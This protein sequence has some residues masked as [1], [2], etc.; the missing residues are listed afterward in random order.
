MFVCVCACLC[1]WIISSFLPLSWFLCS[2]SSK[3]VIKFSLKYRHWIYISS[4]A[5]SELITDSTDWGEFINWSAWNMEGA[6]LLNY[7]YL[8][9][10][11]TNRDLRRSSAF[12]C[13]VEIRFE[14]PLK[15]NERNDDDDDMWNINYVLD[16]IF[17]LS[18]N[19]K[20]RC[21]C[22]APVSQMW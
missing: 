6:A 11:S 4:N 13:K 3:P 22:S 9:I 21:L 17:A 18:H 14:L 1:L 7:I 2:C 20:S 15:V 12:R 10:Y 19:K 5:A 8:Y 16:I